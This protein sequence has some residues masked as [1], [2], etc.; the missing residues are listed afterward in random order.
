MSAASR[1][2]SKELKDLQNDSPENC[3]AGPEDENLFNW[4]GVIIGPEKTPYEGGVFNL[5][6]K[7]PRDYPFKPPNVRFTTPI[8]HCNVNS[9]GSICLDIL[10]KNWSPALT[11]TK[12]LLSIC[13]LLTDP[14]PSDPYVLEIA[15][16]YNS[17]R[18][19]HDKNA[20]KFTEKYA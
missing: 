14:N 10:D 3:S 8:Y 19:K 18:A 11:I 13:S 7:F 5:S 15:D 20:K 17:N 16:L 6:I 2:I 9:H 1:R 12:V 4:T